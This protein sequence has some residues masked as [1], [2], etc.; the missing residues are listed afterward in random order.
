MQFETRLR[1]EGDRNLPVLVWQWAQPMRCAASTPMGG[2]IG[3]RR[4]VVNAQVPAS[5][6]R[7][8]PEHHLAK[9]GVSLGLPGRG[10]GMVTSADVRSVASTADGGVEVAATVGLGRLILA[11]A[12]DDASTPSLAGTINIVAALPEHLS[13]A[14]LISAIGTVAEAKAQALR[15]LGLDATGTATDSVCLV[16]PDDGPAQPARGPRSRW[17]ARLARAAHEAILAGARP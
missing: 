9:L 15:D 14:A 13:D 16:C 2:G 1:R 12:P 3:L 11:A 17:G 8:D 4:W 10:V 5:F 7:R 6:S